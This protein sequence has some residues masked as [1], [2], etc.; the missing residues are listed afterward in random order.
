MI[1]TPV[2][3][4][5][6][7][8]ID[9]P[10]VILQTNNTGKVRNVMGDA[11]VRRWLGVDNAITGE[12]ITTSDERSFYCYTWQGVAEEDGLFRLD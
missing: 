7:I 4:N 1:F 2:L 10:I 5:F 11:Y 12:L 3:A 9:F 6:I 8:L